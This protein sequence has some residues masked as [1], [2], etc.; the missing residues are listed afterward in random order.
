MA[1]TQ[2]VA[3]IIH[4]TTYVGAVPTQPTNPVVT[5][6]LDGGATFEAPDNSA[7][8]T[9]YGISLNLS[10]A[11]TGRAAVQVK[12][13]SDNCD[14]AVQ[15]C[16]FED[17]YSALRATYLDA[18][19]SSRLAATWAAGITTLASWLGLLM[20]KVADAPTLAEVNATT[21]GD[22]YNNTT[23]A[24]EALRDRGDAAWITGGGT[25][26][27]HVHLIVKTDDAV[28]VVVT[29]ASVTVPGAGTQATDALGSTGWNL[30]DGSYTVTVR[31]NG[32]YTPA[33][34]YAVTV[35]GGA[36]TSPAGGILTVTPQTIAAPANPLSCFVG[37]YLYH[38]NGLTPLAAGTGSLR[39]SEIIQRPATSTVVLDDDSNADAPATNDATGWVYL[40][41]AR[42]TVCHLTANWPDRGDRTAYHVTV[43][44]A[45]TY[46]VG[47]LFQET[48][49]ASS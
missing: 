39:V 18:A 37:M 25:G 16:Y 33:A 21:A 44:D 20:G 11:E 19:I 26:S 3:Q 22:T 28:P 12:V 23:D 6:S 13:V 1:Y 40:E 15:T 7:A 35:S 9:L 45:A 46:D 48:A 34:S 38:S 24:L 41:L 27:A 17:N 14:L 31:S 5:V 4:I 30:D 8:T 29:G 47:G 32:F 42:G 36:I 10:A 49:P 43:P 2:G